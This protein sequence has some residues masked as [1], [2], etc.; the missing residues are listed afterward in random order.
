[1]GVERLSKRLH[2]SILWSLSRPREIF[3]VVVGGEG[4]DSSRAAGVEERGVPL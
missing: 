2:A 3:S 1:M 4:G